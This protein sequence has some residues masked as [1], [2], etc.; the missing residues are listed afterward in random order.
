[1]AV[2]IKKFRNLFFNYPY[3]W[4]NKAILLSNRAVLERKFLI[5]RMHRALFLESPNVIPEEDFR[6]NSSFLYHRTKSAIIIIWKE[7]GSTL[8]HMEQDRRNIA[9]IRRRHFHCRYV[10]DYI[11]WIPRSMQLH[12]LNSWKAKWLLHDELTYAVQFQEKSDS[13]HFQYPKMSSLKN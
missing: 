12:Y 2:F 13:S 10:H 11:V 7:S 4:E 9:V 3:C 5:Y 1:M 6:I 8:E